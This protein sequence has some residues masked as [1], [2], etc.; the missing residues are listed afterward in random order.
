MS[1][2]AAPMTQPPKD[3]P[4]PPGWRWVRLGE[5]CQVIR[6]VTFKKHQAKP[7]YNDHYVPVLR[8]GNIASELLT[9]TDLI[10]IPDSLVSTYQK[11]RAGDIVMCTSS[12][13]SSVVGKTATLRRDWHGTVG[14]FCVITRPSSSEIGNFLSYWFRSHGFISWRDGQARGANI[15]NLKISALISL[16][17]PLPPVEEQ[18]RIVAEL[19]AQLALIERAR[20]AAEQQVVTFDAMRA[21][22]MRQAFPGAGL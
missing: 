16:E 21:A 3:K 18:R 9:D 12:G 13:S 11:L 2:N 14:A 22:L 1:T 17:I 6:G 15:Q 5:V 8:A 19:D 10:W 20:R 4:L 7:T